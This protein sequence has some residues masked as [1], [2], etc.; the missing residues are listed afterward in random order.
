MWR[1]T[2]LDRIER[3]FLDAIDRLRDGTARH[4]SHKRK[5]CAI[6]VASV[7]RESGHSRNTL[8]KKYPHMLEAIKRTPEKKQ[9]ALKARDTRA[10]RIAELEVLLASAISSNASLLYRALTAESQLRELRKAL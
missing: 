3:D 6:N 10:Q 5:K 7:S 1:N 2:T 4:P 9:R 8:Y